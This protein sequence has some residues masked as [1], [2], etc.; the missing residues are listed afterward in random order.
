MHAFAAAMCS[1]AYERGIFSCSIFP[2]FLRAVDS[3]GSRWLQFERFARL[4][5]SRD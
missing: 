5:Y 3:H 4:T 1:L 2:C